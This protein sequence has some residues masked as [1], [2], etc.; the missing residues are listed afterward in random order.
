MSYEKYIERDLKEDERERA[1]AA[2]ALEVEQRATEL[3]EKEKEMALEQAKHYET[4]YKSVTK[5]KGF[6]C[7]FKRFWSLGFHRC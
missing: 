1:N 4:L 3:A 5:K 7:G 2:R 6:W